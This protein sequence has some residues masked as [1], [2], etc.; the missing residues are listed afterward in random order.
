MAEPLVPR[1]GPGTKQ[2][3]HENLSDERILSSL[4]VVGDSQRSEIIS[5]PSWELDTGLLKIMTRVTLNLSY[6][7][8]PT[9]SQATK[10]QM[11]VLWRMN[12]PRSLNRYISF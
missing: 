4:P 2:A 9:I 8:Q 1:T 12:L 6:S 5:Y 7:F 10:D 11:K 3:P